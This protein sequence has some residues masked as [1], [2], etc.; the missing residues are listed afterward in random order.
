M[1][2]GKGKQSA[3]PPVDA[4]ATTRA[5]AAANK[6]TAVANAQLNMINQE[7]PGGNLEYFQRGTGPDGTPLY[8]ARQTLSPQ[9][10]RIFD[11]QQNASETYGKTGNAL[12]SNV[13]GMLSKPVDMAQFGAAPTYDTAFRDQQRQNY[14]TRNQP[15]WD[16]RKSALETQLANQGITLGSQAYNDAM[17]TYDQG[18][19]DY[20][21]SADMNASNLAGADYARMMQGRQ[22]QISEAFL[23]RQQALNEASALANGTQLQSPSWLNTPQSNIAN[24]DVVG[25]NALQYQGQQNAYNQQVSQQNAAMGGLFGLGGAAIGSKF[26]K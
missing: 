13:Q 21:L 9:Q 8:T 23:P 18:F 26:W 12:L 2:L 25:A 24:T 1:S 15:Q 4:A 22:N 16:Q 5:Q 19:N 20:L 3:P 17:R 14:I 6:E 11:L 7:T 10:Q